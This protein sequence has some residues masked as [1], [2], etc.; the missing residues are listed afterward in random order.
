MSDPK[1][2]LGGSRMEKLINVSRYRFILDSSY[3]FPRSLLISNFDKIE[4]RYR[5]YSLVRFVLLRRT[6][7]LHLC[8]YSFPRSLRGAPWHVRFAPEVASVLF[9]R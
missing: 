8:V 5:L 4:D 1:A 6:A 3:C 2:T 7:N 9:R